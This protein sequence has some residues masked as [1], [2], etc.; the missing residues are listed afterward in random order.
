[1]HLRR[2]FKADAMTNFLKR[3]A[4]IAFVLILGTQLYVYMLH[5]GILCLESLALF[6][7]TDSPSNAEISSYSHQWR[8]QMHIDGGI[9][10]FSF[11][12]KQ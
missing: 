12:N 3:L 10:L 5:E 4:I 2:L 8:F 6:L 9:D 11:L 7:N 1:M